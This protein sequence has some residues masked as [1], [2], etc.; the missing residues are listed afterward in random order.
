MEACRLLPSYPFNAT[1]FQ[2]TKEN[3][4]VANRLF[5][6]TTTGYNSSISFR[7]FLI[8]FFLLLFISCMRR[9]ERGDNPYT[10]NLLHPRALEER[11]P[12]SKRLQKRVAFVASSVSTVYLTLAKR[13]TGARDGDHSAPYNSKQC[14]NIRRP[15]KCPKLYTPLGLVNNNVESIASSPYR[16]CFF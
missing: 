16:I 10:K 8:R 13:Q 5:L 3:I 4:L 7:G 9:S 12:C 6:A 14:C 11:R 2:T 1:M 15:Q